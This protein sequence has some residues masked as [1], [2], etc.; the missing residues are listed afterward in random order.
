[1]P[2]LWTPSGKLWDYRPLV[3]LLEGIKSWTNGELRSAL[4]VEGD[5]RAL[6]ICEENYPW[7]SAALA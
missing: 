6:I 7:R 3:I 2:G 5:G 4:S 1:M